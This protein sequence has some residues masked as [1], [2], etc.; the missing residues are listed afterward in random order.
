MENIIKIIHDDTYP[1][2]IKTITYGLTTVKVSIFSKSSLHEFVK[3]NS[4]SCALYFLYNEPRYGEPSLYIGETEK[5]VDRLNQHDKTKLFW[6]HTIVFQEI[7][8]KL[9]KAHYK[10]LENKTFKLA[11]IANRAYIVNKVIPT[12]SSL[13]SEDKILAD[14]FLN[15]I[16]NIL[17]VTNFKFLEPPVIGAFEEDSDVFT[18][19]S[20]G[21]NVNMRIYS[22]NEMTILK[23]SICVYECNK[24]ID[25]KESFK[26]LLELK[27]DLVKNGK[28]K[29][30]S[31]TNLIEILD[32]VKFDSEHE[33]AAFALMDNIDT[34]YMWRN[35]NGYCLHESIK[36][37]N[38]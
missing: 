33:A 27:Q 13:S 15:A 2:S 20:K 22:R 7:S 36:F 4:N 28:A 8:G 14:V 6:T 37:K 29:M 5:I 3:N 30:I 17:V 24:N 23:N 25:N 9:N 10:Y 35:N 38:I 1:N 26:N 32:D 16:R 11:E 18:L 21:A 34:S 19:T 12:K 31:D